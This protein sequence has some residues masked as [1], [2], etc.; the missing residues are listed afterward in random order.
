[1]NFKATEKLISVTG[2]FI[3]SDNYSIQTEGHKNYIGVEYTADYVKIIDDPHNSVSFEVTEDDITVFFFTDHAH[4]ND[5]CCE[6]KDNEPDY[7]ERAAEFL[8]KLF[9]LPIER[10]YT[11]KG[12][13]VIRDE[14]WFIQSQT[15]KESCAGTTFSFAGIKNIFKKK[16]TVAEAKRFDK[17]A[18]NFITYAQ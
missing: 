9:T 7:V 14:S 8:E 16:R 5:Y 18:G 17:T 12:T 15:E 2:N 4:F 13:K 10:K 1:M 11:L 3:D 6:L